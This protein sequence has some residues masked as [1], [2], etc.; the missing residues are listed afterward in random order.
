MDGKQKGLGSFDTREDAAIAYDCA[1]RKYKLPLYR[2]NFPSSNEK[3]KSQKSHSHKIHK[4]KKS[5]KDDSFVSSASFSERT[6]SRP[7]RGKVVN[8]NQQSLEDAVFEQEP[9]C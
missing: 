2:L 1:V 7:R 3:K 6:S 9:L 5:F 4:K 8:Y